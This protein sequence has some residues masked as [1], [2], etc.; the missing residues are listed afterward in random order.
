MKYITVIFLSILIVFSYINESFCYLNDGLILYF[1]FNGNANDESSYSNNGDVYGAAL[2]LDRFNNINSAYSFDGID[3]YISVKDNDLLDLTDTFSFSLCIKQINTESNGYRIIDKSIPG[4]GIIEGYVLDT[5][6]NGVHGNQIRLTGLSS[7]PYGNTIYTLNEWQHIVVVFNNGI[8]NFYINGNFDGS[9]ENSNESF[10]TNDLNIFIGKAHIGCNGL[11]GI[12]EH[13]NGSIDDIRIYNRILNYDEII[14]LYNNTINTVKG[15]LV[16]ASEILGYTACVGGST[17]T[18]LPYGQTSV[19]NIFGE[20]QLFDIP[21]GEC[22]LQIESSYF[23][24][25]TKSIQI[26][27]GENILETI[28]IFKPKCNNMYTQKEVDQLLN[29]M[30]YEKDAIIA[31]KEGTIAQLNSSIASMYTQ[32]YLEKAIIEAEKRGELKYDINNDGKVGLEEVIKY[33]E[34][35][36]GI[37]IESLI[38]FPENKKHFLPE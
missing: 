16:T 31:E 8:T 18:A 35:L 24:N 36:S 28:E 37:R 11:C 38:I 9:R 13:F 20:F 32:G 33:L 6:G 15:K 22:I 29:Q 14:K 25:L 1:P 23:Q 2:T 19:T 12:R 4:E 5:Y 26:S 7:S 17:I 34:T 3:D 21:G 10:V 27:V 30:Q